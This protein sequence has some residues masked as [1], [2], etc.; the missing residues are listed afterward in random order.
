MPKFNPASPIVFINCPHE[1]TCFIISDN[2]SKDDIQRLN[3]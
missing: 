2:P 3:P 1:D